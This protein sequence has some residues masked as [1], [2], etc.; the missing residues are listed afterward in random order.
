M[1]DVFKEVTVDDIPLR[2]RKP[3]GAKR[4][5]KEKLP[6]RLFQFWPV[7]ATMREFGCETA[8]MDDDDILIINYFLI[9]V[10]PAGHLDDRH[11]TLYS[12]F[13]ILSRRKERS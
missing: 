7:W 11:C 4:Q 13:A 1:E 5:R 6:N 10:V 2:P 3:T 9:Q 8:L 12:S